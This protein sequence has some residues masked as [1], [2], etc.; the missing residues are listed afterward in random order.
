[1][2]PA[3][4]Y[5]KYAVGWWITWGR[6]PC[7][8]CIFCA[9]F[10]FPLYG[11]KIEMDF[12]L[13]MEC[14]A[15]SDIN[16]ETM[17]SGNTMTLSANSIVE[18]CLAKMAN[19]VTIQV[20]DKLIDIIIAVLTREFED[21]D[22]ET[23][24][25]HIYVEL[26]STPIAF[27]LEKHVAAASKNPKTPKTPKTK[28]VELD[29]DGNT[30]KKVR[31][32][33]KE[34]KEKAPKATKEPKPV[35]TEEEREAR[36]AAKQAEK[37]AA[38]E[39][40]KAEKEATKDADKEAL[41]AAA[42]AEKEAAKEAAK[43]EKEA[44]KEAAKA[45]KEAA[46]EAAKLAKPAKEQRLPI[47]WCGK[48]IDGRCEALRAYHGLF[49][50]CTADATEISAFCPSCQKSG[51]PFGTVTMRLACG[52]FDY[53]AP[54]GKKCVRLA[55][56][57]DKFEVEGGMDAFVAEAAKLNITIPY[58]HL[59]KEVKQR[60]RPK[61]V[62]PRAS[63]T[64]IATS[65]SGSETETDDEEYQAKK[66]QQQQQQRKK[67]TKTAAA[68]LAA[69]AAPKKRGR[70]AKAKE[71]APEPTDSL[72]Q[73]LVASAKKSTPVTP[74]TSTPTATPE[75]SEDVI[76]ITPISSPAAAAAVAPAAPKKTIK[77]KAAPKVARKVVEL[78]GDKFWEESFEGMELYVRCSDNIAFDRS[79][80]NGVGT[81]DDKTKT[82]IEDNDSEDEE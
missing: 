21:F 54:N 42:K 72:I 70:P 13:W 7:V 44:N 26:E 1:V 12:A 17:N 33:S 58:E 49:A 23:V 38:K 78:D 15:L 64:K 62:S 19:D 28:V 34:P 53:T 24:R 5:S 45:E 73:D 80:G 3:I 25:R 75:L 61:S 67:V 36:K 20:R 69:D 48:R 22:G 40:R 55:N 27:A 32:P 56:V 37:E 47:P 46:K 35:L 43:A 77:P 68:A 9:D 74:T 63:A 10:N 30:V 76:T 50:Q 52:I 8:L 57:L 60:G 14:S 65:D 39:A 41:K 18:K 81:W 59:D 71:A 79:N 11:K 2:N 82:V 16:Y 6:A 4:F 31:T 66:Q 29:A 51:A